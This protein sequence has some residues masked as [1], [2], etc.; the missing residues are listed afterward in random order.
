MQQS[1]ADMNKRNKGK[2]LFFSYYKGLLYDK[3]IL[4]LILSKIIKRRYSYEYFTITE[5]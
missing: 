1:I 2:V 5:S 3:N 4:E